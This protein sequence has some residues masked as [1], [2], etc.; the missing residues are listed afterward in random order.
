MKHVVKIIM[1]LPLVLMSFH[2]NPKAVIEWGFTEY[3]FGVIS[4]NKAVNIDF[5]FKN[6]GMIPLVITD[7]KT[8]CG[9]TVP[10]YPKEPIMPGKTGKITVTFD[11]KDSGY[12]SKTITVTTNTAEPLNYLYIKGTVK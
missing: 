1:V 8:S 3:D 7:V 5:E 9:C 4:R 10:E 11:A 6:P 2:L 12:F